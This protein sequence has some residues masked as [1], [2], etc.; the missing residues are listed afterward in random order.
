MSVRARVY[1][2]SGEYLDEFKNL[3]G[4]V[5]S[6][7]INDVGLCKF[8]I[9]VN[10][11]KFNERNLRYGNLI[12]ITHNPS[13]D[14]SGNLQGEVAE[15]VGVINTPRVWKVG[16]V[17]VTA[18]SAEKILEWRRTQIRTFT[19]TPAASLKYMLNFGERFHGD[20]MTNINLGVIT[21]QRKVITQDYGENILVML[22]RICETNGL[23]FYITPKLS[24]DG[25]LDL[26]INLLDQLGAPTTIN[27]FDGQGGNIEAGSNQITEDGEIWN[28]VHAFGDTSVGVARIGW[29]TNDLPSIN[30]Y[31]FRAINVPNTG[32]NT[33]EDV[34][35]TSR[36]FLR[37]NKL[38]NVLLS[39]ILLDFG[40]IFSDVRLGNIVN[41]KLTGSGFLAGQLGYEDTAQ[42]TGWE[43][44]EAKNKMKVVLENDYNVKG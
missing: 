31:G 11:T 36:I 14:R 39:P 7:V 22:K 12:Y 6:Q 19:G 42:I 40:K 33:V 30:T 24:H 23:Y 21:E 34:A 13:T 32:N 29:R 10:D 16:V 2:Y 15:W 5:Y 37:F 43:Y 8:T 26:Y 38:P 27:I 9:S 3:G 1:T 25:H 20:D 41:I 35:Q 17:E 44:D 18:Y 28:S 4:L